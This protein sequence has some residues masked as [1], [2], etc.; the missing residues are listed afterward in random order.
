MGEMVKQ[1]LLGATGGGKVC[2]HR[3]STIWWG[4][5]ESTTPMNPQQN[6]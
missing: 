4:G 2:V 5:G 6:D 1:P 3:T